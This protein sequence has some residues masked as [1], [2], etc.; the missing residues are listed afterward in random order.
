MDDSFPL[1]LVLSRYYAL[2]LRGEG[3]VRG[4]LLF[5]LPV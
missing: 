4:N 5:E 3:R 1:T 2:S